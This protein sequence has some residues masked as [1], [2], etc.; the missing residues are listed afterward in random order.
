MKSFMKFITTILFIVLIG[1]N[2]LYGQNEFDKDFKEFWKTTLSELNT[3][4]IEFESV[5]EE[6]TEFKKTELIKIKSIGNIYFYLWQSTPLEGKGFPVRIKFSGFG[7]GNSDK[8]N[9][10]ND[11][12]MDLND[13]ICIKV[14]IRGQGL[15]TDE[16]KFDGFLTN[17]LKSKQSYIYRGA[18]MD[19]VRAVDYASM[20][21]NCNGD[22][23]V[24]GGSQGGLL[25]LVATALNPKV[26]LCVANFPFFAD[27]QNYNKSRWPLNLILSEGKKNN[28]TEQDVMNVLEYF[29]LINF[30]NLIKSPVFMCCGSDDEITPYEGALKAYN[31]IKSV[32]KL[33]YVV[34]CKGHGCSSQNVFSND[35]QEAFINN[36]LKQKQ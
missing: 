35:L 24:F 16:I 25:A 9:V 8:N 4:P 19:T 7:E 14:D 1:I 23:L 2:H 5:Y 12:F 20:L 29:D 21:A 32:N 17:G 26:D 36:H 22:I 31:N 28:L 11:D 27:I 18:F 6:K 10:P 33:F 3:V 30:S 15:S 13:A 34:N